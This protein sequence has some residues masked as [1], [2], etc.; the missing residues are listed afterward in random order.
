MKNIKL[1]FVLIMMFFVSGCST[2]IDSFV[3]TN[4]SDK[5]IHID[6]VIGFNIQLTV[7]YLSSLQGKTYIGM[8]SKITG[9]CQITWG[10][11]NDRDGGIPDS[12]ST[13]PCIIGKLIPSIEGIKFTF[14]KEEKWIISQ[15]KRKK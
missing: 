9:D 12:Y 15:W 11:T 5:D 2:N 10:Y 3:F 13:S 8:S 6:K 14:T 4:L 1:F 7:G